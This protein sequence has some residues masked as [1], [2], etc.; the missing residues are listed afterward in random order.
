MC[1][2]ESEYVIV[3]ANL[4]IGEKYVY[5]DIGGPATYQSMLVVN[6]FPRDVFYLL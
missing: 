6:N 2:C 1:H 5:L 4:F 3:H